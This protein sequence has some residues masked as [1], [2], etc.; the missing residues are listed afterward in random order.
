MV[1]GWGEEGVSSKDAHARA[2]VCAAV[3]GGGRWSWGRVPPTTTASSQ[4]RRSAG[5][6]R[7]GGEQGKER[8]VA[9]VAPTDLARLCAA[10]RGH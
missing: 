5:R 1:E 4:A 10:A 3:E 7:R 8:A 9:W 6:R 2:H